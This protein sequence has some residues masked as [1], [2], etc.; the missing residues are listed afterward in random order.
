MESENKDSSSPAANGNLTSNVSEKLGFL[1]KKKSLL[2]A[3][4][5]LIL[6]LV[7]SL[8]I[9]T[10]SDVDQGGNVPRNTTGMYPQAPFAEGQL[11]VKYKDSYTIEEI[12][13]LKEKLE[14]LGV[15]SQEKV[16]DSSDPKLSNYYLI[17]FKSGASVDQVIKELAN[18][19]EIEK[20]G[21]NYII[22]IQEN[23]IDTNYTSQWNLAKISMSQAWDISKGSDSVRVAVIDSGIDY[24]HPDLS[25]NVTN[26]PDFATCSSITAAN[27]CVPKPRDSDSFDDVGHGTHVA[28]II[29][30]LTNNNLGIAGINWNVTLIALKAV[31]KTPTSAGGLSTD[32]VD[33]IR[34]AADNADVINM[35]LGSTVPC[36]DPR[37]LGYQ[38]AVDY[39]ISRGVVVIAAAGNDAADARNSTPGSCIGVIT[40]GATDAQDK[41]AVF[42]NI[43]SRVD[44]A[45]PGVGILST[46]PGSVYQSKQ[47]TSMAAPH[48]AAAAAL[49][50]SRNS[51][52]TVNQVRD[53]LLNNSD[54]ISAS[55]NISVR[56]LNVFRALSSCTGSVP[57]PSNTPTPAIGIT[58]TVT[59]PASQSASITPIGTGGGATIAIKSPTPTPVK[60]YS[61]HERTGSDVSR[62]AI[63]IGDLICT[64]L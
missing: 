10:K 59:L 64:P 8:V 36:N 46:I 33:A 34:Y 32:I 38:D 44:I 49:L 4:F 15:V 53:C 52:L 18:L 26:G 58:P 57:L 43:G 39:A 48:V 30:A 21:P 22:E 37:V 6:L 2:L 7:I 31:A 13:R 47:G 56:R 16:F 54:P 28:G 11:I 20:A 45:A 40:V 62:D 51:N 1:Q 60:K 42:S 35:S 23:P 12:Q 63:Q 50:L 25:G 24:N 29:G 41:R 61:C 55:E 5:F 9:L 19:P 3:V 14:G 27:Q 17:K